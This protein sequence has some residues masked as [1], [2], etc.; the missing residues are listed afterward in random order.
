METSAGSPRPSHNRSSTLTVA[1]R[2]FVAADR[3]FLIG[4]LAWGEPPP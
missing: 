2:A 1:E 4:F 3:R